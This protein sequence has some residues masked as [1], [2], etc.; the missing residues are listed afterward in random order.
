MAFTAME[1][2]A[3]L[4]INKDEFDRGM[5]DAESR[6]SSVGSTIGRGL[7]VAGAAAG[8]AIGAVATGV[9]NLTVQSVNAYGEYEQLTGGIEKLY[10]EAADAMMAHASEAFQTT[11][12]D[13]NTYMQSVTTFSAGLISALD[14]DVAA[15][16]E[17]AD[18]AMRDLAD[19]ANTFG[20]MTAE[21]LTSVYTGI[22]K[23]NFT[24]L[25]NLNL[26]FAGTQQGMIDLI[27]ASGILEDEIDSLDGISLDQMYTAIHEVQTQFN[28]TG[29]TAN[30]AAG[31]IQGSITMMQASWQNLVTGL[32][33][34]NADLGLLIGNMVE[35]VRTVIS[36]I[37]PAAT[38]ALGG[39]ATLIEQVAPM[40]TAELPELVDTIL[41][42]LLSAAIQITTALVSALPSILSAISRAIPQALNQLIPAILS[43]TPL[44]ISAGGELL[45][46]MIQGII[47]NADLVVGAI[48][49][50]IDMMANEVLTAENI[51]TFLNLTLILIEAVAGAIL[52]NAPVILESVISILVNCVEAIV[53]FIPDLLSAGGSVLQALADLVSDGLMSLFGT[54]LAYWLS[55][56][57][58][59]NQKVTQALVEFGSILLDGIN[60]ILLQPASDLISDGLDYWI[61]IFSNGFNSIKD[62]IESILNGVLGTFGSIFDNIKNVVTDGI[63]Y[64]LEAFDFEWRF[65]EI[66]LP[67]FTVSGGEAPWGFGG[68]GQ[69]PS[70]SVQWYKKAYDQ[71]FILNDP[72]IFGYGN[73]KFLGG[74]DGHGGEIVMG[75]EKLLDAIREATNTTVVVPVYIGGEQIDEFVV[76]SNQRNDYISGGRG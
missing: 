2:F 64:I 52:E 66:Q 55:F 12:M 51:E 38:Q 58:E 57:V 42:P 45:M 29:T 6:A 11:G 24:L 54:T 36:N 40:I 72:T 56:F 25:D 18:M 68:Q 5:D 41:P 21:E 39:I 65:P 60:Y 50:V 20:T 62:T 61:T 48:A 33:D 73:G 31:T 8:A 63:N 69:L 43:I 44:L 9:A 53:G 1:L 27:N 70:V 14:G 75:Y 4:A 37:I 28:I 35:S 47:D 17:I 10:G 76:N 34:P 13:A 16:T 15:A 22:A 30:E 26:G 49:D 23:G 3:K 7:A 19:N 67:H 59:L 46:G 74:G 71:P 32:A